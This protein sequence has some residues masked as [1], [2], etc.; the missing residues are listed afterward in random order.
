MNKKI[1]S[2]I[3]AVVL[4]IL[5]LSACNVGVSGEI[6]GA[7]VFM[8]K[9]T[10][11]AFGNLMYAGMNTAMKARGEKLLYK[12][13]SEST[14]AAQVEMLDTLITQKVSSI[15]ISTNGEVGFNEVFKRA[16]KAGIKIISVDSAASPD[17]R[18]THIDQVDPEKVGSALVQ[19]AVLIQMRIDYPGDGKLEQTA[20]DA[21]EKYTGKEMKF[22]ILSSC[23]DTPIQNLWIDYMR[24]ELAKDNYKGKVSPDLDIKYGND[25]PNESTTQA[26]AFVAENKVD[27]IISPTTIGLAAAGQVL[28]SNSSHIKLTGLGLPSEM[29]SFMPTSPDDNAF[30]F[31]CPYMMLWNLQDLGEITATAILEACNG[32]YDGKVG[33]TFEYKGKTYKT[34]EASD[35]G[36]SVIALDPYIFYKDNMADWINVL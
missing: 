18:V 3:L 28:K 25:E 5:P 21:L 33:S 11:N 8:F 19:S 10:G 23:V 15:I 36:T 34:V 29:Q 7:H 13:P 2:L 4:F 26:N 30:D 35:G 32:N 22:G 27:I 12:S 17:Y 9:T 6:N 31:V 24:K 14:V 1:I 20:Y 16:Q